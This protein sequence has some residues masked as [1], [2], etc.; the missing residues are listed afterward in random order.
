MTSSLEMME[1]ESEIH[2]NTEALEDLLDKA[3]QRL[4]LHR[5]WLA[6][7][8]RDTKFIPTIVHP[9][10]SLVTAPPSL[11]LRQNLPS[12]Q[13]LPDCSGISRSAFNAGANSASVVFAA[14]LSGIS[15]TITSLNVALASAQASASVALSSATDS[16]L[17]AQASMNSAVSAAEKSASIMVASAVD[18]VASA[19]AAANEARAMATNEIEKAEASIASNNQAAQ[20]SIIASQTAAMNT[21]KFALSLTFAIL[22]SSIITIILF[23]SIIRLRKRRTEKR[24]AEL[25]EKIHLRN[26]TPPPNPEEFIATTLPN[27]ENFE[28]PRNHVPPFESPRR[29]DIPRQLDVFRQP[30]VPR[31]FDASRPRSTLLDRQIYENKPNYN[32]L[33]AESPMVPIIKKETVVD[34]LITFDTEYESRPLEN[35]VREKKR[36]SLTRLNI[37]DVVESLANDSSQ[38][39]SNLS[40]RRHTEGSKNASPEPDFLV[41]KHK[42]FSPSSSKSSKTSRKP[43]L[44]YDPKRPRDPPTFLD[45]RDDDNISQSDQSSILSSRSKIESTG[46]KLG[47]GRISAIGAAI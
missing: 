35:K 14:S 37:N 19:N 40:K 36:L 17:V 7:L 22:G 29:F 4:S 33:I 9:P 42:T 30:A 31:Q 47:D 3:N 8:P 13:P 10:L 46:Q 21:T 1:E 20:A 24:Q 16:L 11:L 6:N 12:S 32:A 25:K 2:L 18:M 5:D 34:P 41:E 39:R 23:Y 28:Q 43:T 15:A 38:Q 44:Q 45:D 27:T 26:K